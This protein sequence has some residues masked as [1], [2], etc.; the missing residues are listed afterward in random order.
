MALVPSVKYSG[1]VDADANYPQ[2]K[3]RNAGTFQDGTG[4]PLEKDWVNDLWGFEQALLAAGGITPSG[5]PDQVG[6]SDYLEGIKYVAEQRAEGMALA[7]WQAQTSGT[8]NLLNGATWNGSLFVAV[9]AGGTVITSPDG[10]TW[11]TRTSGTA[12]L[13]KA[14]AWNGSLFV[15]VGNGGTVITSPDGITWTTRTSGTANLLQAVAWNGSLF[16]AVGATGTIITSSN[17]I[18]WTTRTSGTTNLLSGIAWSGSVWAAVGDTGTVLTSPDGITWTVQTAITSQALFS[19]TWNGA[20]LFVTGGGTGS[21]FTSPNGVT[22]TQRTHP[23]G[24]SGGNV[25]SV[26]RT[27][28]NLLS[29]G[30]SWIIV[31]HDGGVT[32]RLADA[33]PA[34]LAG[35]AWSG[36][37]AIG[38]G[39]SGTVI[40]SLRILA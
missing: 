13:L 17:G 23:K 12:N 34:V 1:Q 8:A 7:N 11:T 5:N 39:N 19:V 6:A 33:V 32:W 24:L 30:G 14:V 10:I 38:C 29:I 2:G 28:R 25:S 31:S 36:Q 37:V 26:F 9:G 35:G 40:R 27:A 16:V 18:S 15:A 22:W 20:S 3:A 21:I 4:T